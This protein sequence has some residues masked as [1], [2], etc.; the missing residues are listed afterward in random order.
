[1]LARSCYHDDV[2]KLIDQDSR[3]HE[4]AYA[5]WRIVLRDGVSAVSIRDVAAEAGLAVGSV[6]HVFGS[7]AEL[8]EYSMA[9]VH[10]QTRD[11]VAA[12][13]AIKD[14]RR[15]AEAVLA[16]LLPLDDRRR[17]EMA[18]NMAVVADS[19][20]HPALRRVALDAQQA[21]SDACAAV[22]VRLR[23]DDL[24][25]PDADMAYETERL[26]ALVDGLAL[27]ALTTERKDLRPKVILA[28][29]RKHLAGLEPD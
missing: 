10:E 20:S 14:P 24:I 21:V 19:P 26:H 23:R 25:R 5:V 27:H 4:I 12:H 7:K 17:M 2:P 11:R 29:L 8:L 9:L 28:L 6:R 18:V 15:F 13:F 3:R 1:M 22:L 16:E